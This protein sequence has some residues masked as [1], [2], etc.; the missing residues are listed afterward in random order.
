MEYTPYSPKQK[1]TTTSTG[2]DPPENQEK[3]PSNSLVQLSVKSGYDQPGDEQELSQ[4][5]TKSSE[6][7]AEQPQPQ[8]QPVIKDEDILPQAKK[9]YE[10]HLLVKRGKQAPVVRDDQYVSSTGYQPATDNE[11]DDDQDQDQD[12]DRTLSHTET[13]ESKIQ[14]KD[15]DALLWF[16]AQNDEKYAQQLRAKETRES[17]EG[18]HTSQV[19]TNSLMGW[20]KDGNQWVQDEK[21]RPEIVPM[22]KGIRTRFWGEDKDSTMV[23]GEG[24]KWSKTI[25]GGK[26]S[27]GTD[28]HGNTIGNPDKDAPD[29]ALGNVVTGTNT[30]YF[31]EE[32]QKESMVQM[33]GGKLV[34]SDGKNVDTSGASG[35]GTFANSGKGRY[36][37]VKGE[38]GQVRAVDPWEQHQEQPRHEWTKEEFDGLTETQKQQKQ[39]EMQLSF[40]NHSSLVAGGNMRAGGEMIVEDGEVKMVNDSSGHY[41]PDNAMTYDM[42]QGL[43]EGGAKPEGMSVGLVDKDK[44]GKM[45][46]GEK[47]KIKDL[48]AGA[49]EF[50]SYGGAQDAEKR[51][52][53]EREWREQSGG[54]FDMIRRFDRSKLKQTK[55][56]DKSGPIVQ[57]EGEDTL[58]TG[59]PTPPPTLEGTQ[60]SGPVAP[61]ALTSSAPTIEEPKK[62][63]RVQDLI[64]FY[65]NKPLA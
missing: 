49:L 30:Q 42:V 41:F 52:R 59:A 33:K 50:L 4:S 61:E 6:S 48:Y 37:F 64:S 40:V 19:G 34:G 28:E 25:E 51:M 15:E 43:V 1:K 22:P 26:E 21:A 55:T 32:R 8:P 56:N 46:R 16:K 44:E 5:L 10:E 18:R 36:I 2:Y 12:Q 23:R 62:R 29:N 63:G 38:D 17:D 13:E 20:R 24:H 7:E 58:L 3:A 31:S 9:A 47:D 54:L 57:A 27:K 65:E 11:H 14:F 35:I 53:E 60:K 45:Q 39:K